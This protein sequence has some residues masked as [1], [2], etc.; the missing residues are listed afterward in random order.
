[1]V[2]KVFITN[3][4]WRYCAC[5]ESRKNQKPATKK[6]DVSM[7][8]GP[9]NDLR[10]TGHIGY[11]GAVF[12]DV[13]FIGDNY[14]KLPMK[15]VSTNGSLSGSAGSLPKSES[16]GNQV[17]NSGQGHAVQD[18]ARMVQSFSAAYHVSDNGGVQHQ[19]EADDLDSFKMPDMSISVRSRDLL[20]L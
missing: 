7:I 14:T 19:D 12:G 4:D 8:S 1:M 5:A 15:I 2:L 16:D 20:S 17:A 13:S 10:H 6:L 3:I 11:D 18:S 9:G